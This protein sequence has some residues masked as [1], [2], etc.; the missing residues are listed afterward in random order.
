M[1]TPLISVPNGIVLRA[2]FY[3]PKIGLKDIGTEFEGTN[4]IG[5]GMVKLK[6][7]KILSFLLRKI[8]EST[9]HKPAIWPSEW[10]DAMR[11]FARF[12]LTQKN[13]RKRGDL[14]IRL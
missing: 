5:N 13:I 7:E 3:Y 10:I 2:T 9:Y 12:I 8:R 1:N 4:S 11:E 14:G 6:G